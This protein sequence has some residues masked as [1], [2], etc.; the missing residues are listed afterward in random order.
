MS[1]FLLCCVY[2]FN[3]TGVVL[4][5]YN[6]PFRKEILCTQNCQYLLLLFLHSVLIAW[7]T[8]LSEGIS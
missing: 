4:I 2:D 1:E 6:L 7:V 8:P 3:T 5:H